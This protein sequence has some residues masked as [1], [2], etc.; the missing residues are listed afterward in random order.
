MTTTS[1]FDS[2]VGSLNRKTVILE[3]R[4]KLGVKTAENIDGD[5]SRSRL[6]CNNRF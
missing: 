4:Q 1:E 5:R 6:H 3:N 2:R